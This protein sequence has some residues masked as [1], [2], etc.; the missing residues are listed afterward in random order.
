MRHKDNAQV[1]LLKGGTQDI[2][3]RDDMK[4]NNHNIPAIIAVLLAAAILLGGCGQM[5]DKPTGEPALQVDRS[6][7]KYD[8]SPGAGLTQVES[9]L[10]L[11]EKYAAIAVEG[12]KIRQENKRLTD[13]NVELA[14]NNTKLQAELDQTAKELK[15]ANSMLIDMRVEINNWK[16]NVLGFRDE[17]RTSQKAQLEALLRIMQLLGGESRKDDALATSSDS[18]PNQKK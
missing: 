18:D 13:E 5:I 8:G 6:A 17:M 12:E 3:E 15:E 10:L 1:R 11:S 9:S 2:S 4:Q 14:K 7:A 16:N